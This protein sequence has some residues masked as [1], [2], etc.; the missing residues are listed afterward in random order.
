MKSIIPAIATEMEDG[1][2]S[3]LDLG[4]FS[5]LEP[6]KAMLHLFG[7]SLSTPAVSRESTVRFFAIEVVSDP[8]TLSD[9]LTPSL[10]SAGLVKGIIP[11]SMRR[12]LNPLIPGFASWLRT[13][14]NVAEQKAA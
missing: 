2:R 7:E 1:E 9:R 4:K 8:A 13:G 14:G 11:T 5:S 10:I 12:R 3:L 6:S